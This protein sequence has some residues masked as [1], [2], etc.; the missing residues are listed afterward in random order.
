MRILDIPT[1]VLQE[2]REKGG[3]RL[4]RQLLEV[5]A[6][7]A[8]S[9]DVACKCY[10]QCVREL[11]DDWMMMYY[12]VVLLGAVVQRHRSSAVVGVAMGEG[13][14][15][16]LE[17]DGERWADVADDEEWMRVQEG[18]V[19]ALHDIW[20]HFP[21]VSLGLMALESARAV[22]GRLEERIRNRG[23]SVFKTSHLFT[24]RSAGFATRLLKARARSGRVL[25][26]VKTLN[27][28]PQ[29]HTTQEDRPLS[30]APYHRNFLA[31]L[32]TSN[33]SLNESPKVAPSFLSSSLHPTFSL[34]QN[35]YSPAY[36]RKL[37]TPGHNPS[38][39][40]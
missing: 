13:L 27:R 5:L 36:R 31:S 26:P 16:I 3:T 28:K 6:T 9:N 38:S 24:F 14:V 12:G 25:Q 4:T 15:A 34:R 30:I 2:V 7:A 23:P 33:G 10:L 29:S 35:Q 18:A 20:K 1:V 21:T 19:D 22:G 37:F 8:T 39:D 11:K 17:Q 40:L 32:G